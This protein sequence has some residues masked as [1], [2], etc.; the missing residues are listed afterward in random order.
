MTRGI[1]A[2][3]DE[4]AAETISANW[5]SISDRTDEIVP[6]SGSVQGQDELQKAG[7]DASTLQ[8]A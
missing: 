4:E 1:Y 7:F 3:L 5:S 8:G 2:G 6:A